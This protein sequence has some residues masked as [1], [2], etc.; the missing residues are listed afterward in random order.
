MLSRFLPGGAVLSLPHAAASIHS[1]RVRPEKCARCCT[2]AADFH[3]A[4]PADL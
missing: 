2:L 1:M 3:I 4:T